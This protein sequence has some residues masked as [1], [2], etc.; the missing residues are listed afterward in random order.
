MSGEVIWTDD[1]SGPRIV[2]LY[3]AKFLA[4]GDIVGFNYL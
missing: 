4:L 1:V 2:L 3:R